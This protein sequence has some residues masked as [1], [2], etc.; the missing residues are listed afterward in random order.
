MKKLIIA[1]VGSVHDGSFN[2]AI[3]LID[4]AKE[5]NVNVIKFQTEVSSEDLT[6]EKFET[7][8]LVLTSLN[9]HRSKG[10]FD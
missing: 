7:S 5:C 9:I 10:S 8:R 1:E 4:L 3:K 2:N 6:S